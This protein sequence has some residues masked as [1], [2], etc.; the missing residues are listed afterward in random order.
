MTV[1]FIEQQKRI[2]H[3]S[4]SN[5]LFYLV[6]E[7]GCEVIVRPYVPFQ[8]DVDF[9]FL[10]V[11]RPVVFY[12]SINMVKRFYQSPLKNS[13]R[14]FCW[15]DFEEM[16]CRSY[17]THWGKYLLQSN[18]AFYTFGEIIRLKDDIYDKFGKNNLLFIRPDTN[19]KAFTGE[20]VH[21]DEFNRWFGLQ[22][23][24]GTGL[25]QLCVV[26]SPED[27]KAEYRLVV[28]KGK[29]IASSRYRLDRCIDKKRG[30]PE[31]VQVF[32]EEVANSVPWQPAP[33]YCMDI[34]MT[35]KGPKLLEI[36]EVN[37]AGFYEMDLFPIAKAMT[38]IAENEYI[39]S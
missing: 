31:E 39:S 3:E 25:L 36:G 18:Y 11:D 7:L 9:S 32:S 28:A 37:C 20:V 23:E 22:Q 8:E 2:D 17:Y 15:F 33:I 27:I 26:A 19:D 34:A 1:W 12:G 16:S 13:I 35:P 38:E 21:K 14:P 24:W 5:R 29:V 4:V 10:P 30:C 6:Q